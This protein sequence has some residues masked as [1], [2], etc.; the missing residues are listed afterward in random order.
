VTRGDSAHE[1]R[2]DAVSQDRGAKKE[3]DDDSKK[4]VT[5]QGAREAG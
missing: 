1:Y 2:R 5:L 3:R 4:V